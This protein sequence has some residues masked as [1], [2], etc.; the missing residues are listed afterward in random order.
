MQELFPIPTNQLNNTT[1]MAFQKPAYSAEKKRTGRKRKARTEVSSSSETDSDS[2]VS[3][4]KSRKPAAVVEK[5]EIK[6][7]DYD[8]IL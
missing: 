3:T 6:V 4:K 2:D 8:L 7:R 5:A 1:N